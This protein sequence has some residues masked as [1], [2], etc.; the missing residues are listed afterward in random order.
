M[1]HTVR[2]IEPRYVRVVEQQTQTQIVR[3]DDPSRIVQ[4]GH[5]GLTGPPASSQRFVHHQT[6]PSATWNVAHNLGF[7][8][9]VTLTTEGGQEIIAD[10][11]HLSENA[12]VVYFVTPMKGFAICS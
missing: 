12:C 8:P 1:S 4:V 6:S 9:N 11:V 7:F 3:A 10:I 2:I 5:P